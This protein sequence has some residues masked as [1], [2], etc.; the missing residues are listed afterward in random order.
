MATAVGDYRAGPRGGT[1]V[2][3][4][5]TYCTSVRLVDES[6][7]GN[8]GANI[9]VQYM[10]GAREVAHLFSEEN[11]LPLECVLRFTNSSGV[12]THA[13]GANGHAFESMKNLKALLYGDMRMVT[14]QREVPDW[15]TV[16]IDAKVYAPVASSQNRFAF[17][18]PML[19][20]DPFWRSTTLNSVNPAPNITVGGSA[21]VHDAEVVF[22]AGAVNPI[23]THTQADGTAATLKGYG[24]VP[25]G[26]VRIYTKD[27][28]AQTI[29]GGADWGEFFEASET[30]VLELHQGVNGFSYSGGGTALIEWRNKYR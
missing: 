27:G 15:G 3:L 20:A 8:R 7:P 9:P 24:T 26:G 10:H 11:L 1:L 12:I 13:D 19:A 6:S 30:Y 22:P 16:Q 5:P 28:F 29:T 23:L 17:L 2:Q 25:A 4:V 14:I 18:F 21:P